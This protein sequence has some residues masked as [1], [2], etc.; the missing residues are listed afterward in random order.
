MARTGWP[1]AG[2][3][4][5]AALAACEDV[6]RGHLRGLLEGDAG[7]LTTWGDPPPPGAPPS[8]EAAPTVGLDAVDVAEGRAALAGWARDDVAVAAVQVLVGASGP[9]TATVRGE[10]WTADVPLPVAGPTTLIVTAFDAVGRTG[11][12]RRALPGEAPVSVLPPEIVID[13]PAPDTATG[14]ERVVLQGRCSDAGGVVEV[15]VEGRLAGD[16]G[17][18]RTADHFAR[19]SLSVPLVAGQT[20]EFTVVARNAAGRT[21]AA[22]VRVRSRRAPAHAP[23]TVEVSPAEGEILDRLRAP[24]SV[25]GVA[26]APLARVEVRVG[27]G[28]WRRLPDRGD[29]FRETLRLAPGPNAVTVLAWDVDD[30][31]TRVDRRWVVDD[32]AGD[33]PRLVLR[34]PTGPGGRVVLDLDRAGVDALFPPAIQARTRLVNLDPRPLVAGALAAIRGACFAEAD[35]PACPA[36]WGSAERNLWKLLNLTPASTDVA[37]TRLETAAALS[38][39]LLGLPFS[40]LL[41]QALGLAPDDAILPDAALVEGVV[42]Q[43]MASHPSANDDGTLPVTLADG[44]ADMATLAPRFGPRGDHPGFLAGQSHAEVLTSGFRMHLVADSNI[45][46]REGVDLAAGRKV[47][48]ASAPAGLAALDLDFMTP[49]RFDL[50]GLAEGAAVDFDFVLSSYGL[51]VALGRQAD[52]LPRGDGPVWDLPAWTLQA[53]V[54]EAAFQAFS[55]LRAGCDLCAGAD[56]GALLY[57]NAAGDVDLAEIAVGRVGHD[58]PPE[59][60]CGRRP[61]TP[62]GESEHFDRFDALDCASVDDCA[63]GLRCHRAGR[64]DD[65]GRCVAPGDVVCEGDRDC[66]RGRCLAGA[67]VPFEAIG[68][69]RTADCRP[70]EACHLGQCRAIP[71]GWFRVWMPDDLGD[72]PPAYLWD[73]V[74]DVVQAR[75]QDEGVALD[76]AS[77]RFPLQGIPVGLTADELEAQVRRTLQTQRRWLANALLGAVVEAPEP[78]DLLADRDAD[79]APW[80]VVADCAAPCEPLTLHDDTGARVDRPG[81]QGRAG[82]PFA[83]LGERTLYARR[84]GVTWRLEVEARAEEVRLWLRDA[85]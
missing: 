57:Q 65:R 63:P 32:G 47:W 62:A 44:L 24:V 42:R 28:P 50:E 4:A 67:C 3:L 46:L 17:L 76:A 1:V 55:G 36:T 72:L 51:P 45:T 43:V 56:D 35:A 71:P 82:L 37:G 8:D 78:A 40:I 18:A 19:W 10:R 73:L 68:C 74:V 85:R 80:L 7:P 34:P 61:A 5:L 29:A 26:G 41:A 52:P 20:E 60:A 53:M 22:S 75:L 25:R 13:A 6:D 15:A 81:P 23:P 59:A 38:D 12:V 16:L 77:V 9:Y 83:A 21:A 58:C 31:V 84:G 14:A 79:G 2:L 48:Q 54:A 11:E 39:E 69:G 64:S 70:G 30:L 49:D 27:D 33:G 66:G